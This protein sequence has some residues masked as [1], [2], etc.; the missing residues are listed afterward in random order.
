MLSK[1]GVELINR[2]TDFEQ[3]EEFPWY[4]Y[5]GLICWALDVSLAW[6]SFDACLLG[7]FNN[8]YFIITLF[9]SVRWGCLSSRWFYWTMDH[10]VL[11]KSLDW[12]FVGK[13]TN[14]LIQNNYYSKFLCI[15]SSRYFELC[16]LFF[17]F[18]ERSELWR[19]A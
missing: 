15:S 6:H 1:L 8:S 17:G 11:M 16:V 13:Q 12:F 7:F 14:Y 10:C 19:L 9:G 4:W 18:W 2:I 5:K 3:Y